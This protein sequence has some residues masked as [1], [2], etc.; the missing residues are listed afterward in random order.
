MLLYIFLNFFQ[1]IQ[2][3]K[4]I[5]SI[6]MLRFIYINWLLI[7]SVCGN[8][9]FINLIEN[10]NSSN[11]F[12]KTLENIIIQNRFKFDS[13]S[14]C[15]IK[16]SSTTNSHHYQLSIINDLIKNTAKQLIPN[17]IQESNTIHQN[18]NISLRNYFLIIFIDN[19]KSF[20]YFIDFQI[21]YLS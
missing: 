11:K 6:N 4:V 8:N 3:S 20:R 9:V 12:S 17:Q 10:E 16:Q 5:S 19:Y 7:N 15:I 1:Y 13:L 21:L 18:N 14:I 2:Y